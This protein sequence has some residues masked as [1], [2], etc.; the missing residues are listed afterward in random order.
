MFD[1][2]RKII[3]YGAAFNA[4]RM[5]IGGYSAIYILALGADVSDVAYLKALQATIIIAVDVPLGYFADKYSRRLS[6]FFAAICASIWMLMMA[7]A[8]NLLHIYLAEVFNAISLAFIGGAFT[9]ILIDKYKHESSKEDYNVVLGRLSQTQFLA[10]AVAALVGGFFI[11][12]SDP[13]MWWIGGTGLLIVALLTPLLLPRNNE[14]HGHESTSKILFSESMKKC[15]TIVVQNNFVMKAGVVSLFLVSVI[16]QTII[17]FWQ[18]ALQHGLPNVE[19]AIVYSAV[20][21]GILVVQS[22]AGRMA[23]KSDENT[24]R[25]MNFLIVGMA[26]TQIGLNIGVYVSSFVILII[27]LIATFYQLRY[28]SI[29]LDSLLNKYIPSNIRATFWSVFSTISRIA[30][31]II[32]PIIGYLSHLY[33]VQMVVACTLFISIPALYFCS[34]VNKKLICG[35]PL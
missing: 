1:P 2:I 26:T 18:I 35:E 15:F 23:S 34:R 4:L 6:V 7:S 16:Y 3:I 5:L 19:D 25:V 20:F 14:L 33:G 8:Q 28:I 32:M 21:V 29:F 17:Q 30:L 22:I 27:V 10:M 9:S 24:G 31:I 12:T 11:K 13:Y